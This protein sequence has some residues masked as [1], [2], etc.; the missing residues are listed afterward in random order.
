MFLPD[1][2]KHLFR[3]AKLRYQIIKAA[4]GA[5]RFSIPKKKMETVKI[6]VPP[7]DIQREI[8]HILDQFTALTVGLK[9]ELAARKQQYEYYKDSDNTVKQKTMDSIF[10]ITEGLPAEIAARQQQ[11]EYYRD[12]LLTFKE[13]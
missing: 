2:S 12:K 10:D 13:K 5:T 9:A 1:F 8:V 11:Y 7:I 4:N 6:P 3:S